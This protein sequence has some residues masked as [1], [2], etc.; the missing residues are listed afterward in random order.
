MLTLDS[1][2]V[3]RRSKSVCGTR[4]SVPTRFTFTFTLSK[5][6]QYHRQP[7][8]LPASAPRFRQ[9]WAREA[10]ELGL[11]TA[12]MQLTPYIPCIRSSR[13]H[14]DVAPRAPGQ[15]D[16]A[17]T[18][19]ESAHRHS[20]RHGYGQVASMPKSHHLQLTTP[21]SILTTA[22]SWPWR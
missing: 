15:Y 2:S 17:H 7:C 12:P 20:R 19:Q 6:R 13:V 22:A 18:A 5:H 14:I 10:D 16:D 3:P 9:S 8:P 4:V 11:S 1:I 21:N